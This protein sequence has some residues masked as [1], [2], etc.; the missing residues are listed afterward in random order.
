MLPTETQSPEMLNALSKDL[1]S[2]EENSLDLP[3]SSILE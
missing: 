2:Y 1:D 3:F